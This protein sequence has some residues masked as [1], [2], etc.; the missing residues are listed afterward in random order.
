MLWL[1]IQYAIDFQLLGWN[2]DLQTCPPLFSVFIG[3]F[4]A[5]GLF[6][7]A[8]LVGMIRWNLVFVSAGLRPPV[9]PI[10]GDRLAP[11]TIAIIA[12]ARTS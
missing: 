8:V 4:C 5:V 1:P 10:G 2:L 3:A 12:L 6:L 11:F 9:L 7:L